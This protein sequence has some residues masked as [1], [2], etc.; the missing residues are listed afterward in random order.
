MPEMHL[1][2]SV[3]TY[4]ACVPF[5]KNKE[6]IQNITATGYSRYI[7]QN[8][9]DKAGFWHDMVSGDFKDISRI[10]AC[11]KALCDKAFDIAKNPKYDGYQCGLA[12]LVYN[13]FIKTILLL[14]QINLLIVSLKV[15]LCQTKN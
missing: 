3:F 7:Y 14:V 6:R 12:L 11:D 2:Q 15:K 8:K 4:S 13:S 10:T 1:R 5:T 9:L